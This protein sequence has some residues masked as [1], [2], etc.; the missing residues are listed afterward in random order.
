MPEGRRPEGTA[1]AR[2]GIFARGCGGYIVV[3]SP[4]RPNIYNIYTT[5]YA[6]PSPIFFLM[7]QKIITSCF[8]Q[9]SK[10]Q[11]N[12]LLILM[13]QAKTTK[14]NDAVTNRQFNRFLS[15]A[16]LPSHWKGKVK[17]NETYFRK[18]LFR[19]WLYVSK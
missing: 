7:N 19:T 11:N 1:A 18:I 15:K 9:F 12:L 16:N 13:D 6:T 8:F 2:G 17:N 4:T 14:I 5:I 10:Q 3:Y